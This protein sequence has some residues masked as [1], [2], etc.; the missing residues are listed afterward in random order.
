MTKFFCFYC[1]MPRE[2]INKFEGIGFFLEFNRLFAKF[3]VWPPNLVLVMDD[4]T[5][6]KQL[7]IIYVCVCTC[8]CMQALPMLHVFVCLCLWVNECLNKD[9]IA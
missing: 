3:N 7:T 6:H 5:S 1:Q 9:I 4:W 2:L 8:A